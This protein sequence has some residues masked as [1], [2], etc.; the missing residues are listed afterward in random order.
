MPAL[1]AD[2]TH[3]ATDAARG[4]TP[5]PIEG[6]S[7]VSWGAVFAGAVA[8][9]ALWLLLLMLGTGL[10]LSS[11]SPWSGRG[12]SGETF[13]IATVVWLAITQL[14][15]AGM[16][17]YLA[18]RLRTRWTSLHTD[19]VYFRDTAHGFLAWCIAS[20]AIAGLLGSAAAA[21]VGTA[22]DAGSQAVGQ[23]ASVAVGAAGSAAAAASDDA[24]D[25]N[26]QLRYFVDRLFRADAN[27]DSAADAAGTATGD[28]GATDAG[29]SSPPP[30][31]QSAGR[32]TAEVARIFISRLGG[33]ET[34]PPDELRYVGGL[35]ARTTG[36][37]QQ[38]AE[39]RTAEVYTD[40]R[41]S[42]QKA[43]D[44]AKEAADA[45]RK[46]AARASLWIFVT[47]LIGAFIAS[48][49]A[50]YGGYRRDR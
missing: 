16:G 13:G 28:T 50:T 7:G 36:L 40:L 4:R 38:E 14:L 34:L 43:E 19:E 9:A 20:L 6:D 12:A 46:A 29:D 26:D 44:A 17:G 39:Q 37:D 24:S 45:A 8:T 18:G 2:A 22:V 30:A 11:V 47:L 48:L 10:G 1:D 23:S 49:M 15:A 5:A 25:A 42:I 3:D 32:R 21:I 33:D 31:G 27:R 35:V 41:G